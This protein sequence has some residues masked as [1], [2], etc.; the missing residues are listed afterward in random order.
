[1]SPPRQ[2]GEIEVAPVYAP[3]QFA[4]VLDSAHHVTMQH[5]TKVMDA[6]AE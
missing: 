6:K 1:M 2:V 5:Y 3:A 4:Q